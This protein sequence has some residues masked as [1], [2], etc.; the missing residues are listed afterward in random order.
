MLAV[1]AMEVAE[2]DTLAVG[3]SVVPILALVS[4]EGD[5]LARDRSV[6]EAMGVLVINSAIPIIPIMPLT[7]VA[8]FTDMAGI[9]NYAGIPGTG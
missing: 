2:E 4:L 1:M 9:L 8:G 5:T 3:I 7:H 6:E